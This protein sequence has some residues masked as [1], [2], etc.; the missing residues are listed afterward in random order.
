[1]RQFFSSLSMRARV[2]FGLGILLLVGF[3]VA[4]AWWVMHPPYGVLFT[5]LRETDA[6]EITSTLSQMQVPYRIADDGKAIMVP[7]E[8]IYDTRMKLIS[9]GVPKGG[10][11]GFELFKDS[12]YGVT[13]FAQRVN[14][15]RALQGELERTIDALDEGDAS[16]VHLT[17]RRTDL[18]D[19]E[20][21]ASK[22]SVTLQPH[23]DATIGSKAVAGI[24]HLV[25]S[26]VDGLVP[27]AVVVLNDRGVVL[28]SG[29]P[30]D[31][32]GLSA[33]DR[34]DAQ[35]KVEA[36]LR[37]KVDALLGRALH[38]DNFIVSVNVRLNYDKVKQVSE[39][40][41]S[42]GRDGN[43]LLVHERI[44]TTAKSSDDADTSHAHGAPGSSDRE[45]DYAHGREQSEVERAPGGIERISVGIVLPS[46]VS[47]VDQKRLSGLVSAGLGL[48]EKRGD[49]VDVAAMAAPLLT[50]ADTAAK[51]SPLLRD[52]SVGQDVARATSKAAVPSWIRWVLLAAAALGVL[53]A[54]IALLMRAGK[55]DRRPRLSRQERQETLLRLRQWIQEGAEP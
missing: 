12:D 29:T 30:G 36:Q 3:V 26:A 31:A 37:N 34:L 16:R 5:D 44:N 50:R 35:A 49:T 27:G 47:A 38:T 28:S 11:V 21:E 10:S 33:S 19:S 14:Y 52:H 20:H 32:D 7:A 40:L 25:A 23:P 51:T 42:Q 8:K 45:L 2:L 15:Q 48:D 6:A 22:A 53:M 1:M 46:T 18:F 13:E 17:I 4:A 55:R 39:R 43:G 9:Q 24:Q 41:L 54:G